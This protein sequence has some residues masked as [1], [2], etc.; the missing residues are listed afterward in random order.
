MGSVS[1]RN[2]I[3]GGEVLFLVHVKGASEEAGQPM[4]MYYYSAGARQLFI[5]DYALPSF[6]PNNL[7]DRNDK[8][9]TL[10]LSPVETSTKYPYFTEMMVRMPD[11]VPFTITDDDKMAIFVGDECRGLCRPATRMSSTSKWELTSLTHNEENI[12]KT[13][14]HSDSDDAGDD[15]VARRE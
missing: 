15:A 13:T 3:N 8:D 1:R 12:Q 5:N 6:E 7:M 2:V 11:D 9:F 14:K 4:T 10:W